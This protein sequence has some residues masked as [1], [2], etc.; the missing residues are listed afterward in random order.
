MGGMAAGPFGNP[1]RGPVDPS[2]KIEGQW[3]RALA[4]ERTNW[5]FLN[6]MRPRN[7]SIMWFACDSPHGS[8]FLPFYASATSGAPESYHSHEGTMSKFSRKVAWWAYNFVNQYSEINFQAINGDVR[9]KVAELEDEA[10][11]RILLWEAEA[12]KLIAARPG[13][14]GEAA[15]ME[16]LTARSNAFAEEVLAR[17]WNFSEELITKFGRHVVTYNDS[18]GGMYPGQVLPAWWLSSP[19]V[20][21]TTWQVTGPF[22]GIL[23]NAAAVAA[24]ASAFATSPSST[25][26]ASFAAMMVAVAATSYQL[27]RRRGRHDLD[28]GDRA[29]YSL[30]A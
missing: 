8:V 12:D 18:V 20:G 27:G 28:R 4:L 30:P 1:N 7:R 15:A 6:E 2:I 22:H 17:W 19:E 25:L 21:Y 16:L 26:V 23:I 3:D 14:A 24:A 13:E 11:H 9:S 29:Y 10:Q 5:C